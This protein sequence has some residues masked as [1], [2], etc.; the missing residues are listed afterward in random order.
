[1]H[2][3]GRCARQYSHVPQRDD[4]PETTR[5]PPST[6]TPRRRRPRSCRCTRALR[7]RRVCRPIRRGSAGRS[8]RIPQWLI[9]TSTSSGPIGG[10]GRSSTCTS[11]EPHERP[12]PASWTGVGRAGYRSPERDRTCAEG[13]PNL[14]RASRLRPACETVPASAGYSVRPEHRR[15]GDLV[16]RCGDPWRH[17][18]R[19]HGCAGAGRPTSPSPTVVV[20]EIGDGLDGKRELDASGH[21]VS[22]G[23]H[24]H[25]HALRRA[26]L[27]GP[28]AH[29]RRAGT[30]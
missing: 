8:R 10:T 27:L 28:G 21:V 30:A 23:L 15:G 16:R 20:T 24:R 22:P 29:A 11:R 19:R 5:S 25:P 4:G 14:T 17:R 13:R 9:S 1:M 26:G 7:S 18:R 2:S 3:E 12:R 6:R